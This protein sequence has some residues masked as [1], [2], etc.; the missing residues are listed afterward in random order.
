M[1][2]NASFSLSILLKSQLVLLK[3]RIQLATFK[4][5]YFVQHFFIIAYEVQRKCVSVRR[6][7]RCLRQKETRMYSHLF[8]T[9]YRKYRK[10][11]IL[12]LSKRMRKEKDEK[13]LHLLFILCMRKKSKTFFFYI[14]IDCIL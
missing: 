12:I 6:G 8:S 2:V 5:A 10:F 4:T 1:V 14:R 3:C 11:G 7:W 9:I 13:S